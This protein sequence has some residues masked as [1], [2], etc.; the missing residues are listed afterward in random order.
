MTCDYGPFCRHK[1][2]KNTKSGS[3]QPA[4]LVNKRNRT[5]FLEKI[6]K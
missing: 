3:N 4:D 1:K 6:L 2:S 5:I